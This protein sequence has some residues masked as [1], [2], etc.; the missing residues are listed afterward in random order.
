MKMKMNSAIERMN[1]EI[2]AKVEYQ[3]N[4]WQ[5]DCQDNSKYNLHVVVTDQRLYCEFDQCKQ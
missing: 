1:A 5:N 4:K 3:N 2:G